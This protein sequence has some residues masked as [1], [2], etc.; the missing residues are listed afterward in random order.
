MEAAPRRVFIVGPSGSGKSELAGRLA[1]ALGYRDLDIDAE[2]EARIGMS[3]GEFMP[4]FGQPSF[5]AIEAATLATA[6]AADGVVVATGGGIVLDP[7][8]WT[9]M[10]AGGAIICLNAA[11]EVL[12]ERITRHAASGDA[13]AVRPLLDGDAVERLRAQLEVRDPLY[14]Q[15]DF[16]LATDQLTPDQVC[17]R[18]AAAVRELAPPGRLASFSFATAGDRSDIHVGVGALN[19]APLIARQRWPQARRIWLVTDS[20]VGAHWAG[21]V[22]EL[23]KAGGFEVREV[24]VPA[25]EAS[26]S[27][28]KVAELCE[29]L[30]TGGATR[31]DLMVALGGGVVGDLAGF[32]AAVTL[33]GLSLMQIPTSLLAMVDSSVGGKTG[34][35]TTGGKN[36]VGAFY[37]P[38]LVIIDPR[39]LDTLPAEELRSGMAEI[40]K[41]AWIQPSTPLGGET[42][43]RSLE[44]VDQL[45]ALNAGALADIV[46]LNVAIKHSVVQADE[47]ETGLR[48]ILNFGHTAGHAIEADG[49]R[50]RHGEAVGLGMLVAARL[51]E[52]LGRVGPDAHGALTE[53]L[54]TTGLPTRI[55]GS[56]DEVIG[57]LARDKKNLDGSQRWILL[58]APAGVEIVSGVDLDLVREALRFNGAS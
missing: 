25:G 15:A 24:V 44:A 39:F 10:R 55:D 41:H 2:I 52:S 50:Y 43:F 51:S 28:Q 23:F 20:N 14:A 40:I 32:V 46:A 5:R 54:A 48:M 22:G 45:D 57:N 49:Y 33:R 38:G 18:I 8:N 56:T 6:C 13:S 19:F 37:Q 30:T 53:M 3:I 9:R 26:K 7:A 27:L 11:P 29:D 35:N 21:P 34:V 31:R 4:R 12:A 47:R 58:G 17:E 16:S 36:M 42:L 1:R